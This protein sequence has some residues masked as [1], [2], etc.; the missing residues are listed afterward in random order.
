M[1]TEFFGWGVMMIWGP[2]DIPWDIHAPRDCGLHIL[3]LLNVIFV[4]A[5]SLQACYF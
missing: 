3:Q 2:T 1:H 4:I 5:A